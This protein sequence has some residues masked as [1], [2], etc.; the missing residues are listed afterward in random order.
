[1]ERNYCK[2]HRAR[3]AYICSSK[4]WIH[5]KDRLCPQCYLKKHGL[6]PFLESIENIKACNI[7]NTNTML[8]LIKIAKEF[9]EANKK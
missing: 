3:T 1:M 7:Y 6:G 9:Q 5:E 8:Q 4:Y 2:G